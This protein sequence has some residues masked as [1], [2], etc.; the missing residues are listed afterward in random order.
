M[1]ASNDKHNSEIVATV[2]KVLSEA[3]GGKA[4]LEA[5]DGL[6]GSDRSHVLRCNVL[7]GPANVPASVVV[8]QAIAGGDEVY[9]PDSP[10]GPAWRLFN[11][12][13]GLQFLSEVAGDASPA[14]RFY[15]GDRESG[16]IVI[17]DLGTGESLDKLL[18][19]N[20][21]ATAEAGLIELATTLGRMHAFTIGK[22]TEY[23]RIR[24][25]LGPRSARN[26]STT[27]EQRHLIGR[28]SE[29]C[30]AVGI[31]PRR[32]FKGEMKVVAR[33]IAQ[34]GPFDAYLHR[35]PCPDNNLR[36]GDALKLLDFEFADFGHALTDGVY[37]RIHF[38]TCW[39]VNRLPAYVV[40][41]MEDA[42]RAELVKGCP[43]AADDVLF[44]R[45]VV[46]ACAHWIIDMFHW[47]A[48]GLLEKDGR[49][50]ISTRRQRVLLRL[51][52]LAQ[53]AEEF[54]H[55]EAIGATAHA[56]AVKLRK[57]WN[58]IEEMPYYP[59]FR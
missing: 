9:N 59:A 39:C 31:E 49:W 51:D 27:S 42:Y 32:G 46:E 58:E 12:W 54:G 8:K 18:L 52:M 53:T 13:A 5:Q 30:D 38:P 21:P 1:G 55:L 14:P 22:R 11:D 20:Q 6:G 41:R 4:R 35:D 26:S 3:F 10:E 15:G 33:F 43:E 34:P 7:E 56:M 19:G 17:E 24:N 25:A 44:Y 2:E 36:V 48:H 29:A 50:G 28:F 37:G 16:L 45:S 40:R 23:D 57:L 47:V